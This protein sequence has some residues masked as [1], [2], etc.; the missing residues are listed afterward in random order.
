MKN[1][2]ELNNEDDEV[3]D[4]F[5]SINEGDD[6]E[7]LIL[8]HKDKNKNLS[9]ENIRVLITNSIRKQVEI[10]LYLPISI[11]LSKILQ[12]SQEENE[13]LLTLKM[14]ALFAYPQSYYGIPDKHIS[15][16]R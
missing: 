2:N 4:L 7:L 11:K 1:K 10:E 3:L 9:L 8:L 6:D 13:T 12:K 15:P 14:D 5:T 16:S